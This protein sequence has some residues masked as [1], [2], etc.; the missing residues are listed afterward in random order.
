MVLARSAAAHVG[1]C[2][3]VVVHR[4]AAAQEPAIAGVRTSLLLPVVE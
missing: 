2:T 1:R 4:I 3:A